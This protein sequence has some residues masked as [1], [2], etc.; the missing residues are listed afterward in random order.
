MRRPALGPARPRAGFVL[1]HS[2]VIRNAE[3][4]DSESRGALLPLRLPAVLS[5]VPASQQSRDRA[6]QGI[7]G[8]RIFAGKLSAKN[9]D[10][11]RAGGLPGLPAARRHLS[12]ARLLG[13]SHAT[14]YKYVPEVTPGRAAALPLGQKQAGERPHVGAGAPR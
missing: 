5:P 3:R 10:R 8:F 11:P 7:F 6:G 9:A 13:V 4:P 2:R 1:T 14:M 12:I